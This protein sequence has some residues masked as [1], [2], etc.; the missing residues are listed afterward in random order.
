MT[1]RTQSIAAV[2]AAFAVAGILSILAA[3]IAS[4]EARCEL[5]ETLASEAAGPAVLILTPTPTITPT[6]EHQKAG[7]VGLPGVG[8]W[9]RVR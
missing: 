9:R 2:V 5:L 1:L 8:I 6:P 3:R 7:A 4:L